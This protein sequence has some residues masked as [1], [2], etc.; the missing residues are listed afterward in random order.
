MKKNLFY[1]VAFMLIVFSQCKKSEDCGCTQEPIV[2]AVS[3]NW[4]WESSKNLVTNTTQTA[5]SAGYSEQLKIELV[6]RTGE[7]VSISVFRNDNLVTNTKFTVLSRDEL[8]RSIVLKNNSTNTKRQFSINRFNG[9]LKV[10]EEV[11]ENDSFTGAEEH[12]YKPVQ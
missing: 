4:S 2:S 6:D 12:I 9:T 3:R 10:S 8:G 1:T 5:Q 11:K 7:Q